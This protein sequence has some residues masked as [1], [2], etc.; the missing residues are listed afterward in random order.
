M[1]LSLRKVRGS[2]WGSLIPSLR[3]SLHA[4]RPSPQHRC[5]QS[6]SPQWGSRA[7]ACSWGAGKPRL[8]KL[9]ASAARNKEIMKFQVRTE[10]LCHPCFL[11]SSMCDHDVT[12]VQWNPSLFSM[13][14]CFNSYRNE[15][16]QLE[17][18]QQRGK[19]KLKFGTKN[20]WAVG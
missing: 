6:W 5:G 3:W 1:T 8:V 14:R 7:G 20:Q 2:P 10:S 15:P 12:D 16:W 19:T 18:T 9:S 11:Y 17:K 13:R 4:V